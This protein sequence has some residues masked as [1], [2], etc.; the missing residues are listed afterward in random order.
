[1]FGFIEILRILIVCFIV[2]VF[3]LIPKAREIVIY[4]CRLDLT[5]DFNRRFDAD[6]SAKRESKT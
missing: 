6:F 5:A 1:M 4:I 2:V 3:I